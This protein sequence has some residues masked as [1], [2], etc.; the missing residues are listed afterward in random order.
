[1]KNTL[2]ISVGLAV[3]AG[4]SFAAR[5]PEM[6]RDETTKALEPK[7][8]DIRACYDGV[9]KTTPGAAGK[10]TVAFDVAKDG[11][12]G[13]GTVVNVKVDK[14]NTTA[15]DAVADCV[16]KTIAGAGPLSP[17]DARQGQATY[18]Y[19]FSAPPAPAVGAMGATAPKS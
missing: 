1:M 8:N 9:L 11:E 14:A 13:A 3:L 19:E 6:Y 12:Q 18:V 16:T 17:A 10:V 5:S 7:N 4:C 15:P 2:L